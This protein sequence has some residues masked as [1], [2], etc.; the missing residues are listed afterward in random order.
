MLF[1]GCN[2]V[3]NRWTL[4]SVRHRSK[5]VLVHF[6]QGLADLYAFYTSYDH[7]PPAWRIGHTLTSVYSLSSFFYSIT[8]FVIAALIP[9]YPEY[10]EYEEALIWI[11]QGAISFA[12][13]AYDLG[14]PS[15]SHPTDRVSAG[16][17]TY[18]LV[19]KY[20][21]IAGVYCCH[22]HFMVMCGNSNYP[23]VALRVWMFIGVS[24][25]FICFYN[26]VVGHTNL[27]KE[28]Y[29][30]YH[31]LWHTGFPISALGFHF[32]LLYYGFM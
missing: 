22:P 14:R 4:S 18:L 1:I 2:P 31:T 15:I 32:V 17:V 20:L 23:R 7:V 8:G 6:Y 5:K 12:C 3:E 13:D 9:Y 16:L 19:R 24:Y 25:S 11:W 30:K 28:R 29:F 21:T 27:D 10:F 26:A